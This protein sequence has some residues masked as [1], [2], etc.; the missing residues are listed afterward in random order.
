MAGERADLEFV[1]SSRSLSAAAM[2]KNFVAYFAFE[3][4]ADADKAVSVMEK[5]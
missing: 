4:A 2:G 1:P 3:T 5:L